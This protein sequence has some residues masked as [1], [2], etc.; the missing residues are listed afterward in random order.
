MK[1]YEI[2]LIVAMVVAIVV[3]WLTIA[4]VNPFEPMAVEKNRFRI[5]LSNGL[6][7]GSVGATIMYGVEHHSYWIPLAAFVILVLNNILIRKYQRSKYGKK[8]TY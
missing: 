7:G 2:I 5:M 8:S 6:L 1:T 4:R 3:S